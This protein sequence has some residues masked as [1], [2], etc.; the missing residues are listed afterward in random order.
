[1][2]HRRAY[3]TTHRIQPSVAEPPLRPLEEPV[4]G[5]LIVT[6]VEKAEKPD[7]II[8]MVVVPSVLDR[9]HP[10]DGPAMTLCDEERPRRLLIEW[11][12]TLIQSIPHDGTKGRDPAGRDGLVVDS[13]RGVHKT[14]RTPPTLYLGD[15]KRRAHLKP[16]PS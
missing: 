15:L 8:V 3:G 11:V 13:P 12:S 10:P 14:R 9:R 6:T 5:L 16:P 7:S 1:M 4:R 2:V